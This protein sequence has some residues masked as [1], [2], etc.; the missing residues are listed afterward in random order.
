MLEKLFDKLPYDILE[1]LKFIHLL[2]GAAGIGV[3][4]GTGYYFTLFQTGHE[5]IV[6]L[7]KKK[8]STE[9]KLKRYKKLVKKKEPIA[10]ELARNVGRLD[11]MKK[12]MPKEKEMPDLLRKVADFGAARGD[13][14]IVRF[15]LNEGKVRD[16]YKEIPVAIQMRGSFWDTLDFLDR[17]QNLL[18]LVSFNDLNMRLQKVQVPE[19]AEGK[20]HTRLMLLTD[21]VANTYAYV[22]GAEEKT[23]AGKNKKSP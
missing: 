19:G 8:N 6:K 9:R 1:G 14:D 13:F 20:T 10:K 7:E 18:Q 12:Q 11:A 5:E 16:Y 3:L 22:Q 15:Q 17:M 21:F 2:L 23:A 4:L